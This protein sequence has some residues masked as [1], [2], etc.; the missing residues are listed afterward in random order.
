MCESKGEIFNASQN[1]G[2]EGPDLSTVGWGHKVKPSE[3]IA[4]WR[5][6]NDK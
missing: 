6:F 4:F 5:V 2:E 3:D 1:T